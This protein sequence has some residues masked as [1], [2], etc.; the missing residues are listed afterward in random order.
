MSD[1]SR[2][3]ARYRWLRQQVRPRRADCAPFFDISVHLNRDAFIAHQV[4]ISEEGLEAEA[5]VL[6]R[7]IDAALRSDGQ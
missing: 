4:Y 3:A 1:D 7:A 5:K 6:D 2:D